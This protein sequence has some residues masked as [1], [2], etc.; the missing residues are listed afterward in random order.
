[1]VVLGF[2][3][4]VTEMPIADSILNVAKTVKVTISNNLYYLR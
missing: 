1:M 2:S 4:D 3:F